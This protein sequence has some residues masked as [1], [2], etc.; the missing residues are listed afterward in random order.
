MGV[1]RGLAGLAAVFVIALV[2]CGGD[3][4]SSGS[5][6]LSLV[7]VQGAQSA[8]L[9]LQAGT[10]TLADAGPSV[11]YFSNRPE[12]LAGQ[13]SLAAL[14]KDWDSLYGDDPPNAGIQTLESN[15]GARAAVVEL[16]EAPSYDAGGTVTYRVRPVDVPESAPDRIS[17]RDVNLFIDGGLAGVDAFRSGAVGSYC[18][19]GNPGHCGGHGIQGRAACSP[20]DPRCG[21]ASGAAR[22][23]R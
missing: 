8:T 23:R 17:L 5:K 18:S 20:M 9:D 13:M 15:D 1:V 12:R 2:G 6:K 11:T 19:P 22:S 21:G 3:D 14:V 10:L 7:F 16:L 4:D